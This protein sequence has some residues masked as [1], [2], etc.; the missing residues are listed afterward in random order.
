[1]III[2]DF[3]IASRGKSKHVA[4][5]KDLETNLLLKTQPLQ[6]SWKRTCFDLPETEIFPFPIPAESYP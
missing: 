4:F 2:N 3:M 5:G 6:I 1:M